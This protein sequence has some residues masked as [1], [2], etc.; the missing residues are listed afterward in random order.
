MRLSLHRTRLWQ[1][2]L[3]VLW[4]ALAVKLVEYLMAHR[5]SQFH[6]DHVVP[7]EVGDSISH[8]VQFGEVNQERNVLFKNDV[9]HVVVP[10]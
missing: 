10:G 9:A 5:V 1:V 7:A 3:A 6:V 8:V 2:C 4:H